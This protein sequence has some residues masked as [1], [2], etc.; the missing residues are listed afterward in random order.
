MPH[1]VGEVSKSVATA[2]HREL[3]GVLLLEERH[4]SKPY[5]SSSKRNYLE[6][7]D[8]EQ[9]AG[10]LRTHR[11]NCKLARVWQREGRTAV[12]KL[13]CIVSFDTVF[14]VCVVYLR[15]LL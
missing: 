13:L 10:V 1:K 8:R 9:L 5:L 12:S 3:V 2:L 4:H 11:L 14:L 7:Q 6:T 15:L